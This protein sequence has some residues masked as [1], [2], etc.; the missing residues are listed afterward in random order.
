MHYNDT[1][2]R[3]I[4]EEKL[5]AYKKLIKEGK[6]LNHHVTYVRQSGITIVEY[7]ADESVRDEL[8]KAVK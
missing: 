2:K 4:P 1:W 5:A 3:H 8:K 6:I 7:D